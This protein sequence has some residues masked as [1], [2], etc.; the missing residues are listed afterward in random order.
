[1]KEIEKDTNKWKDSLRSLTE[2]INTFKMSI[3]L[4]PLYRLNTIPIKSLMAIFHR[5]R[6][7]LKFTWNHE[8]PKI[9]KVILRNNNKA[10][11]IITNP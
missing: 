7:I 1:M 5:N 3:L 8:R 11:E 2:R 6:T 9:V 10:G 4:K